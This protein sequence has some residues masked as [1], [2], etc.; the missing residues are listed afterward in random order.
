MTEEAVANTVINQQPE[1][2]QPV[3]KDPQNLFDADDEALLFGKPEVT[4]VGRSEVAAANDAFSETVLRQDPDGY[5]ERKQR[6]LEG[7]V[8]EA[9]LEL[10]LTESKR[11]GLVDA[12][13][14]TSDEY[15]NMELTEKM[16]AVGTQLSLLDLRRVTPIDVLLI[17]HFQ[18][19]G[20]LMPYSE[21]ESHARKTQLADVQHYV[22]RMVSAGRRQYQWDI[23][24]VAAAQGWDSPIDAVAEIAISDLTPI[25]ALVDRIKVLDYMADGFGIDRL[26]GWQGWSLGT[27]RQYLRESLNDMTRQ[28]FADAAHGFNEM[29]MGWQDD[30]IKSVLMTRYTLLEQMEAVFTEDVI[31]GKSALNKGDVWLGNFESLLESVFS[32]LAVGA[33]AKGV[34][35]LFSTATSSNTVRNAARAAGATRVTS[36]MD[37]LVQQDELA[38]EMGFLPDEAVVA[39]LP[40]PP[41]MMDGVE[42]LTDGTKDV[43]IRS[44]RARSE[45]L[46]S[47]DHLTG[48]G[49]TK[50]DRTNAIN[51]TLRDLDL[52]DHPHVQGRMNTLQMYENGTGYKMRVVV[53][54]TA[55]GGFDDIA[56]AVKE[57]LRLDEHQEIVRIMRINQA[58]VLEPVFMDAHEFARAATKGEVLPSTAGRIAGGD[59]ADEAFYLVYDYE[60]FWHTID[61]KTLGPE[62]FQ[63]GGLVP[64]VLLSPN[65]KFGDEIYGTFARAH[66][67]EQ[68]MLKNFEILFEPYYKLSKEDKQ[69][70]SSVYEWMEDFGKNHGRAPD[71]SELVT[72]YDGITEK[73]VN[74]II[75]LRNGYDT[76]HELFNR[77]L[78]RDYKALGFKTAIPTK[79]SDLPT[80]HG[81][82]L[83]RANAGGGMM[84]DPDTQKMVSMTS[85]E[86]DDLYNA[87]GR[88][89]K[90]DMAIDAG[91]ETGHKATRILLREDQYKVGELSTKPQIYHPGYHIRFH[92]DPYFIIKE[93]TGVMIDG[94]LRA[95]KASTHSE[96]IR[97]SGTQAEAEEFIRKAEKSEEYRGR[98]N[99]TFR[100]QRGNDISQA[101]STLFMKESIH[102]EGRL[103][104]DNRN[105][106]RLPDTNGNLATLENPVTSLERG[107]G[108]AARQL[109]HEDPLKAI[110]DAWVNDFGHLIADK[111][112]IRRFDLKEISQR[113]GK[114]IQN[115]VDK[116]AKTRLTQ[117][118]ELI[119]YLRLIEGTETFIIP[120]MREL[121]L[122][123]A[124]AINNMT[125]LKSKRLESF[126]MQ[127]DPLRAMRS[128]AF[129]AFM[130][131]R[132]VRQA[133]LQS[134]QISY[135]AALDPLYV[136]STKIFS[137]AFAL[138]RGLAQLRLGAFDD[139]FS[140]KGLAKQMGITENE[141]RV[142]LREFDRS[143]VLD[144]VDVH[145][146]AG[147]ASRFRKTALPTNDSTLGSIGYRGRQM[148]RGV[149]DFAQKWG[150]NFGERNNLTFTYNLALRRAMK[151]NGYDSLLDMSRQDWDK[152]RLDASNLSLGMIRPN[153]FGYQTGLL[154]VST[155][156]MA[157]SH[158]AALG[159]LGANPAIK[160]SDS[161][162]IVLGT[163]LL[164][165]ANMYGARDFAEEQLKAIGVS[166]REIPNT[167]VSL[168]DVI[169]AGIVDNMFTA[170]GN[171]TIDDYK[172]LDISPFAPGLDIGRMWEMQLRTIINQPTKAA[173]GPFGNIASRMMQSYD[174]VS[175]IHEGMP[176][177]DPSDKF[178]LTSNALLGGFFPQYNDAVKTYQA[179]Q[180][181]QWYS[182][183]NKPLMLEPTMTTML[184][185][186]TLGVRT[187]EEMS[188]Y[189]MQSKIW[190]QT[191][192]YDNIVETTARHF[193]SV[194]SQLGNGTLDTEAAH[195]NLAAVSNLWED[196][197]EGVRLQLMRD[198]MDYQQNDSQSPTVYHQLIDVMKNRRIDS[199][200]ILNEID[201]MLTIPEKKREELKQFIADAH[202]GR[203]YAEGVA[204]TAIDESE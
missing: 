146:F 100:V 64:R 147:G 126:A 179:Y 102:R 103:F 181:N 109:T 1:I 41:S 129:N 79:N 197:P 196:W 202:D 175:T 68:G 133:L 99:V 73:Q 123:V 45:I 113:L 19:G 9:G 138:R 117:G 89:M 5:Q 86:L 70:V 93:T 173:F 194:V 157:F 57:A 27:Y 36:H 105:F 2:T 85:R 165:G 191:Q 14:L 65:A 132:P 13:L 148:G 137:D 56:D 17:H 78:Y 176:D 91:N 16:D 96:A 11:Q 26:K 60:S 50:A 20:A 188:Y 127:M 118:K 187:R 122:S 82:E 22:D 75:A 149:R 160:G 120:K 110:K 42:E 87:G 61:K 33:V 76:M 107:L 62:T 156:F 112:L 88:V 59:T 48:A 141:Y 166:D 171:M 72:R 97:T 150:F 184:A 153:N 66:M 77:R 6:Q 131:F 203:V 21:F 92:D 164:Y 134:S 116:A 47:S 178:M 53:G 30:P 80:F 177:L 180:M 46:A 94:S 167:G 119:D 95:G 183:S 114:E 135:L 145:S 140:V 163:Y 98:E 204:K 142:L 193:A 143:G 174:F 15:K 151:E 29:F 67:D 124:V 40:R 170:L 190:E 136:G 198:I 44:E 192:N 49:L 172:P 18:N 125:G 200:K 25:Y 52:A 28:E 121:A 71:Y 3:D 185:R 83:D 159:L 139:G 38:L 158:K 130:V 128:V 168:V 23:D 84:L 199:T 104:W 35:R 12:Q 54:E 111:D 31:D 32:V 162:R 144:L 55:E 69:F 182:Q 63:S 37:Q 189:R 81:K 39:Q 186:A 4:P 101:E 24:E 152:L 169:S 115:T 58:G 106:D 7:S 108:M 8:F 51:Q 10:A 195:R 34:K 74:G 154:S 90:L 161:L 155:Q 201:Q 43:I